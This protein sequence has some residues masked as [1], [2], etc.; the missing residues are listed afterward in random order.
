[1]KIGDL[2]KFRDH[3]VKTGPVGVILSLETLSKPPHPCQ[4]QRDVALIEWADP[5]TPRGNY[6]VFLLEVISESR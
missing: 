6:Q 2:V 1:M 3:T 4:P 5:Y